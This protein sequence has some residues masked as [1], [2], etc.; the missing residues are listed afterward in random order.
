MS[1]TF[2]LKEWKRP[3]RAIRW[4]E[5]ERRPSAP[6]TGETMYWCTWLENGEQWA[7]WFKAAEMTGRE[8]IQ[9]IREALNLLDRW[10]QCWE[11][12]ETPPPVQESKDVVWPAHAALDE[13]EAEELST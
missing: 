4:D 1:T 8:R 5:G 11:R 12:E 10:I 9:R 2:D 6:E 3:E 13:I 7:A